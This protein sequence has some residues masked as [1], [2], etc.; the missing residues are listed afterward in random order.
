MKELMDILTAAKPPNRSYEGHQRPSAQ[1][2]FLLAFFGTGAVCLP[3]AFFALGSAA[4][5]HRS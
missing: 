4:D 3:V 5:T 1:P 2:W